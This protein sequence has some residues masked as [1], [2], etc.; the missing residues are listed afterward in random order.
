M[1]AAILLSLLSAMLFVG[2]PALALAHLRPFKSSEQRLDPYASN[3]EYLGRIVAI[4]DGAK[5]IITMVRGEIP[6]DVYDR[7]VAA[8]LIR[9]HERGVEVRVICGPMVE[10]SSDKTHP[11]LDLALNN[12]IDLYSADRTEP[13]HFISADS[14]VL[15]LE[16]PHPPGTYERGILSIESSEFTALE[17]ELRVS[18]DIRE[19]RFRRQ[20]PIRLTKDVIEALRRNAEN[21]NI[22]LDYLPRDQIQARAAAVTA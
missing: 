18:K 7:Q 2:P 19:G 12:I 17:W 8:A 1:V 13:I 6:P 10:V 3:G 22:S 20:P 15:F 21:E 5:R 16:K 4:I 9:A 11:V 14:R